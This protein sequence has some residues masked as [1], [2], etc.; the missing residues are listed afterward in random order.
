VSGSE[1][2]ILRVS[3]V[4]LRNSDGEVLTVRKRN[5]ARFMLPGGK[6]EP[7]ETAADTAVR[8]CA[9][10]VG[11]VL[12]LGALRTVG[13]FLADAA[14]EPGLK[15]EGTVFEHPPVEIAGPAAEIE[16]I[17]WL[18]PASD[19]LPGDLAPL[20]EHFVLPALVR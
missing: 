16:E 13:V 5:T 3:A 4:V 15:I 19:R 8:E 17:R 18:D 12:E 1:E 11:A 9:E 6:P 7:D 20:L 14:N 10:E 2:E